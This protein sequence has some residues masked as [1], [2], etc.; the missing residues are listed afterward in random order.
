VTLEIVIKTIKLMMSSSKEYKPMKYY[1]EFNKYLDVR[2]ILFLETMIH[3]III[4]KIYYSKTI[5]KAY[6][7]E[8]FYYLKAFK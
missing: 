3:F 7:K 6:I 2:C 5:F 4:K 8:K 1:V